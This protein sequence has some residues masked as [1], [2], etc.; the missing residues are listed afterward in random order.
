[1]IIY[2]AMEKSFSCNWICDKKDIQEQ[3]HLDNSEFN[4][5]ISLL[6]ASDM[7]TYCEYD[8]DTKQIDFN[9]RTIYNIGYIDEYSQFGDY[10]DLKNNYF[11]NIFD[12]DKDM[13]VKESHENFPKVVTCNGKD[14]LAADR[15]FTCYNEK[16]LEFAKEVFKADYFDALYQ[17]NIIE[18]EITEEIE[19]DNQIEL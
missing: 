6:E 10:H 16:H 11:Q 8:E 9:L 12:E 14:T 17:D 4:H 1:M 7:L 19:Q 13:E 3:Y 18:H 2:H 15:D 5:V